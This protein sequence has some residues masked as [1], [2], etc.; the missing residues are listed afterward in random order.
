MRASPPP[1]LDPYVFDCLLPDLVGHDK[2]PAALIVY[3]ALWRRCPPDFSKPVRISHQQLNRAT[4]LSRSAV[5]GAL[6][7]LRRRGLIA[8]RRET[9]T[10]VPAHSVLRPWLRR[11]GR[12]R[13]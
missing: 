8:T 5:Q 2:R 3:L 6:H 10:S 13:P 9:P 7:W 1:P 12:D 11:A 4:G